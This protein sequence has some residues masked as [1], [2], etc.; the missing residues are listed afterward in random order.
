LARGADWP[1]TGPALARLVAGSSQRDPDQA[2]WVPHPEAALVDALRQRVGGRLVVA[3]PAWGVTGFADPLKSVADRLIFMPPAPGRL[4]PGRDEV[5]QALDDGATAVLLAPLAGDCVAIEPTA[6]L[7]AERGVPLALDARMTSG[8]RV[9][10]GAPGAWGD[11]TLLS[12]HGEPGPAPCPGAV[13]VSS[14]PGARV[15]NGAGSGS[16]LSLGLSLMRDSVHAEPRLRRLLGPSGSTLRSTQEGPAPSWA[17]AAAAA[18]LQQSAERASQRARHGRT[19]RLNIGNIEGMSVLEEPPGVQSASSVLP[20]LTLR[21]DA[22]AKALCSAGIPTLDWLGG[23]L[24]PAS[25]RSAEAT[26]V[27]DRALLL[28]LHPFYRPRDLVAIGE[29]LRRAALGAMSTG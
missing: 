24:A 1:R 28:P 10:D 2:L 18:R 9:L 17:F 6:S 20:V 19:L 7:C 27:A 14:R 23:W 3:C 12:V 13:L 29:A 15:P 26:D 25:E 8:G 16:P 11:P 5:R 22:V 21:R 4:D